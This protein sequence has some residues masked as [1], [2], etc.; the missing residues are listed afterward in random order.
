MDDL[1]A[2]DD[3]AQGSSPD[4]AV[5]CAMGAGKI[6]APDGWPHFNNTLW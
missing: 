6:S 2:W 3:D 1:R 5:G 4:F